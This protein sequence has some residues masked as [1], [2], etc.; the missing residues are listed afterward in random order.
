MEIITD[1]ETSAR[2]V[3]CGAI[4]VLA[5][6]GAGR[7]KAEF[8]VAIRTV[9]IDEQS[10]AC[11]YGVGGGI[12]HESTADG[13][14]DEAMVKAKVLNRRRTAV[15]LLE[16]MR[17]D[18]DGGI[19]LLD[20]HLNRL[21]TSAR[22]FGIDV[23]EVRIVE[24]LDEVSA[25]APV[26]LRLL[27]PERGDASLEI[28]PMGATPAVVGLAIDHPSIDRSDVFRFHKTTERSVYDLAAQR[29]PS[30]DDVVL[31]NDRREV[32]ETTRSNIAVRIDDEWLTPPLA[33]GCLPGVYR[34][35]LIDYK[36]LREH[37]LF[38]DDL[39]DGADEIAVINSV[40]GWKSAK[41]L[42]GA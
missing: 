4:G 1:L 33:A 3:Y 12:V 42:H 25:E 8:S 2:G 6:P 36:A 24:L 34:E 7:P 27:V 10:G 11:E 35:E 17:W 31:I 13:E 22:Y 18:P 23:P 38:L 20:R 9:S 16:T 19:W 40:R 39:L 41:L 30:A 14:Y 26:R 15:T 37:P 28:H 29:H 5:P 32:V 21:R